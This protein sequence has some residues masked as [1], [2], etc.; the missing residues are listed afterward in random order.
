MSNEPL[1]LAQLAARGLGLLPAELPETLSMEVATLAH[2]RS[3]LIS[4][5]FRPRMISTQEKRN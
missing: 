5:G 2:I 3:I 1:S 4:D